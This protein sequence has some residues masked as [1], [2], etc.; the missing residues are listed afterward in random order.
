MTTRP[1]FGTTRAT[2]GPDDSRRAIMIKEFKEFLLRGNLLDLAV[3][4]VIG[5]AF[6]AVVASIT[7]DIITP[8]IKAIFGGN[9]QFDSLH[10]MLHGSVIKYGSLLTAL[11]NFVIVAAVIFFLIVKPVN[12][13]M[14][15]MGRTP[16]EEPMRACPACMSKVPDLATRCAYCTSVLT[17]NAS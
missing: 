14:A 5:V 1:R 16:S 12:A 9:T 3:A 6:T 15:K 11:L 13:L 7:K 4:V 8:L 17:P 10:V 2:V